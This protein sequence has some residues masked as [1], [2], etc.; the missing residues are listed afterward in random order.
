MSPAQ[1]LE[2]WFGRGDAPQRFWFEKSSATDERLREQCGAA[3]ED[4][5]AGRLAAW[6]EH[7]GARPREALA[8]ILLLDQL[9][10]NL[11]RGS[12]RAFAGD[13]AALSLA[14]RLVAE[15]GDLK[16][17]PLERWFAYLPF[18]HSEGEADQ[19]ESL[20]LFAA[21][22]DAGLAEP[23]TWAR[24]HAE[25]IARFG[26]YPHRNAVLERQSSAAEIEFLSQPG[27]SF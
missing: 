23:L 14:R 21:L 26:R 8:L 22:A 10:R 24:R 4:A 27:S 15:G 19:A 1:V 9:P 11:F 12:A 20:R 3:V 18:E 16:L 2:L 25:V 7:P 17:A 13:P 5:L 6:G